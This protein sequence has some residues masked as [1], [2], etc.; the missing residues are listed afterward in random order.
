MKLVISGADTTRTDP[1]LI[2]AIARARIWFEEL[3]SGTAKSLQDI[4]ARYEVSDGYVSHLLP[5][6]FPAPVIV[7]AIVA[8]QQ[9]AD[10]TSDALISE[11]IFQQI[12]QNSAES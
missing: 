4:D 10:L 6:A 7:E 2:K 3:Q 9:P 5:L 12:G 8:G 1:V 11:L